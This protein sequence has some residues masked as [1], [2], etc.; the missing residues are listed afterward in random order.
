LAFATLVWTLPWIRSAIT[1][2]CIINF[3]P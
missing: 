2:V 3:S 1:K